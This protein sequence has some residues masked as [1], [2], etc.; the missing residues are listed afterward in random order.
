MSD[1]CIY[2]LEDNVWDDFG[3]SDDHIVPRPSDQ[4]SN[5]Y[6]SCKRPR[7]EVADEFDDGGAKTE[8]GEETGLCPLTTTTMLEKTSWSHPAAGKLFRAPCDSGSGKETETMEPEQEQM[9]GKSEGGN[10]TTG[11][12]FCGDDPVLAGNCEGVNN[13]DYNYSLNHVSQAESDLTFFGNDQDN[14]GSSGLLYY[15]WPDDIG[16]FEDVDKMFRSCDATFGLESLGDGDDMCWFPSSHTTE[17]SEEAPKIDTKFLSSEGSLDC[18]SQHMEASRPR[19]AGSSLNISQN[20]STL[21]DEKTCSG[22]GDS[23]THQLV[24]L[25]GSDIKSINLPE[26]HFRL[27]RQLEGRKKEYA[28]E[29]GDDLHLKENSKPFVDTKQS[30]G[31]FSSSE[32]QQNLGTDNYQQSHIP[33]LSVDYDHSSDQLG[34]G[35]FESGIIYRESGYPTPSQKDSSY[36]SNQAESLEN[37]NGS[38]LEIPPAATDKKCVKQRDQ[39]GIGMQPTKIL[40][41]A[42]VVD[43][44]AFPTVVKKQIGKSEFETSCSEIVGGKGLVPVK[45]DSNPQESSCT[46]YVLDDI[47]LEA[48]SFRQLQQVTE[49][50][51]IRTKLCIRDSLYRLARSAV[52]RHNSMYSTG[53][54]RDDI[55]SDGATLAEGANRP[56]G[57]MDI[58]TDTNPIDRSIAHLLFHRP[59]DSSVLP[60]NDPPFLNTN[61]TVQ[62]SI[63][64]SAMSTKRQVL[65]KEKTARDTKLSTSNSSKQ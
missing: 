8:R 37:S 65:E 42:D 18:S 52:Q 31:E 35:H 49:Q 17:S 61:A 2:E 10:I 63:T 21:L 30:C 4:Y 45:L 3:E 36:V 20:K 64:G 15:E 48:T 5:Q 14:K 28:A 13:S 46:S 26:K 62:C 50:L 59:S 27:Q 23:S 24:H 16:N 19:N 22:S 55:D 25:S 60:S 34:V 6:G 43:T 44:T 58:E 40:K 47:S 39:G 12:E 54:K 38:S 57:F 51:D 32:M 11:T 9:S 56:P 41:C 29:D 1:L 33:N 53:G 7:R